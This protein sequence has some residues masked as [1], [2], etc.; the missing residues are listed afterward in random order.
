M[1][2]VAGFEEYEEDVVMNRIKRV[3]VT[4]VADLGVTRVDDP[5]FSPDGLLVVFAGLRGMNDTGIFVAHRASVA[6]PWSTAIRLR[7]DGST[8][9]SPNLSSDCSHLY[10]TSLP[11]V[12]RGTAVQ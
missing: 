12:Y 8:V 4:T 9:I 10:W 5:S 1:E 7:A 11:D 2:S 6:A 3:S